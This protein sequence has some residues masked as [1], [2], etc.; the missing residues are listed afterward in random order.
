MRVKLPTPWL[1]FLG[2]VTDPLDAKTAFGV[3]DW[4]ADRLVGEWSLNGEV[5]LGL[6]VMTP[7]Q[8]VEAGARGLLIGIA[9]FGGQIL[10][11]GCRRCS[12]RS[13]LAWILS[14]VCMSASVTSPR[15]PRVRARWT[16]LF[17]VRH[18]PVPRVVGT[19][20]P[21]SGHRVLTLARTAP[22]ARSTRRSRSPGRCRR[23]RS[24][25]LRATGQTGC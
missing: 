25:R 20:A 7:A 17:D 24:G 16:A 14:A 3:R 6:P 22:L 8:A 13:M 4:A 21:R 1:A 15:S 19:G 9:P 12:K 10:H 5:T 18:A 2:D 23:G 11:P